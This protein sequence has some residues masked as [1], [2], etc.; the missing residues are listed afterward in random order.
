MEKDFRG[1]VILCGFLFVII[2][3]EC[4]VDVKCN[5]ICYCGPVIVFQVI[6]AKKL[7]EEQSRERERKK[8][9]ENATRRVFRL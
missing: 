9:I 5:F 1:N 6:E 3:G 8:N 2:Y 7:P 4:K